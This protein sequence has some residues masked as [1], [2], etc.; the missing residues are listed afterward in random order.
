M[1]EQKVQFETA[2]IAKEKGFNEKSTH[3]YVIGY[4]EIKE[5]KVIRK[6]G[7]Y[8]DNTKL[9]QPVSLGKGQPHLALAPTQ[10]LLQKWLREEH[11]I[12]IYPI[13]VAIYELDRG[14]GYEIVDSNGKNYDENSFSKTCEEALEKGLIEA[15]KLI[16]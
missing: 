6:W 1:K 15:L 13:L 3:F 14:W 12:I 11:N 5:D 8:E 16:E 10:C 4:R 2:K 7:N 9:L